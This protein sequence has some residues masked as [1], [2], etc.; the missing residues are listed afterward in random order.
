MLFIDTCY[1]LSLINE[2]E[3]NHTNSQIILEY[4]NEE[5]TLINST[6]LLEM[7]NRLKNRRYEKYRNVII[8]LLYN[9]D[10]IHYL[11]TEDYDNAL[12]TCKY[13][14]FSINFSDCTIIETMKH[15]NVT[16]IVSFDSDFDKANGIQRIYL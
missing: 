9:M 14:D 16:N 6:V 1:L 3:K 13:Y 12:N 11:T 2:N 7:L 8:D 5:E 15:Y 4:I 10:N